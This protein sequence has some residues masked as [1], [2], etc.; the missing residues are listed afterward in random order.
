MLEKRIIFRV[1]SHFFLV[2]VFKHFQEHP[3]E[4][5]SIS[6]SSEC[7]IVLVTLPLKR[8]KCST[9]IKQTS[10][11]A[12]AAIG[13]EPLRE[14]ARSIFANVY[15][16]HLCKFRTSHQKMVTVFECDNIINHV[17]KEQMEWKQEKEDDEQK[18]KTKV[19]ISPSTDDKLQAIMSFSYVH[20]KSTQNSITYYH[21]WE[22][23]PSKEKK[24]WQNK[25]E[26]WLNSYSIWAGRN[27]KIEWK[28]SHLLNIHFFNLSVYVK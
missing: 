22:Q 6:T 25:H 24:K 21:Q 15:H 7:M 2:T 26:K 4:S 16:R 10:P 20:W 5:A 19:F 28:V 12:I 23:S 27:A 18:K 3:R 9:I 8:K 11:T 13:E 14:N 17:E 1:G